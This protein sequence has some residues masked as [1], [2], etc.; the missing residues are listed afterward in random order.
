[1]R[2]VSGCSPSS[3]WKRAQRALLHADVG[4]AQAPERDLQQL[5]PLARL[6]GR[7]D[8]GLGDDLDQ[9]GPAA[10][11]VHDAGAGAVDA[12]GRADVDEL[13]RI[14]LEVHTVDAHV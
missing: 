4:D 2:A 13:G 14:V 5:E 6:F 9:R 8:V 12:P 10:V 1:M 7:A 11:E 3:S